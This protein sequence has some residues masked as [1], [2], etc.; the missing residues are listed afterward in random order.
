[1]TVFGKAFK[2]ASAVMLILLVIKVFGFVEKQVLAYFF[3]TSFQID[4]YFITFGI[5]IAFWDCIRDLVGPSFLPVLVETRGKSTE[6]EGWKLISI[7][8]NFLAILL[9]GL[10]L[11]CILF[12]PSLVHLIAPGFKG[13]QLRV[14]INLTRI[15]F[16]GAAFFGIEILT[17]QVLNS[18]HRF[19]L[20]VLGDF[21]FKVLGLLGLISL[22]HSFGIY[23]LGIGILVGSLVAPL[24]HFLGLW[25]K[26]HFYQATLDISFAPFR[27]MVIR[28]LPLVAGII[29]TQGRRIVDSAFAST[30]AVGSV[31]ALTFSYRLIDFPF[32]A[33]AEPLAVVL[34]PFFSDLAVKHGK[35]G[36]NVE[37]ELVETLLT[38][39]KT[40]LLIFIPLSIGLFMLRIPIIQLLF[41]RGH[42]DAASTQITVLPLTYYALGM[43]AYALEAL[44]LRFYYSLSDTRT[45]TVLE[46][47]T[48]A[49]HVILIYL[50]IG[51][52]QH[53]GIALA[54]TLSRTTKVLF[55][56]LLLKKK[57]ADLQVY[58][59]L[60]FLAR[61][62]LAGL[63]MSVSI[64][65]YHDWV[66]ALLDLSHIAGRGILVGSAGIVGLTTFVVAVLLLKV[67]EVG[68]LISFLTFRP[69][70]VEEVK[71]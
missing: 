38:A 65:F 33:I 7:L 12:A 55:L 64:Y 30:L 66:K 2:A 59:L 52:L 26:K 37:S 70:P 20:A 54:F 57:V 36:Q 62:G 25:K 49:L 43:T 40:I 48:F 34:F 22:Y 9:F 60:Q 41:E 51:P 56:Y 23:G 50:L 3:G 42:F 10:S 1:M 11:L 28:M 5:L 58:N 19:I 46:G 32:V 8:L 47:I 45:P 6:A 13:E 61:L 67:R 69:T 14:A 27:Q 68:I 35:E 21:S 29:F 4:A 31:S 15:M 16:V 44:L 71:G 18:Y 53:G 24:I 39:V 17:F 63:T